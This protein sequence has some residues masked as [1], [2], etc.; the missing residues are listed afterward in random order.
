[1]GVRM[2]RTAAYVGILISAIFL[3][4]GLL[5]LCAATRQPSRLL[6][7]VALLVVG[8]GLAAWSGFTLSRLRIL[9]PENL[10][11]RITGLARAGGNAEVTLSQVVA[12]LAV[13]DEAALAALNLLE[14]RGQCHREPRGER[15]FYVFPGLKPSKISRRCPY[16]G[17]EFSVKTPVYR[18]PHCGGDVRLERE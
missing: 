14:H 6:L 3:A 16:C 13:P 18:C 2:K 4:V 5:F 12:E 17:G 11:D 7:S 9:D 1:M 15:E 10:S 8:G